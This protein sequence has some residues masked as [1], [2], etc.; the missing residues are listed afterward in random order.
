M[1]GKNYL[2]AFTEIPRGNRS[3]YCHSFQSFIWNQIASFRFRTYGLQLV[4]GDLVVKKK[5]SNE[6]KE[7]EK[8]EKDTKIE[9]VKLNYIRDF[10]NEDVILIDESNINDYAIFDVVL[11]LIGP[12]TQNPKN[13]VNDEIRRLLSELEIDHEKQLNTVGDIFY[14]TGKYRRFLAKPI[15][16][17]Y[18]LVNYDDNTIR[19]FSTDLD[20][21]N[22]VE[23][24]CANE[25]SKLG[26]KLDFFLPS[27]TYATILVRELS[28]QNV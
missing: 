22:K 12:Q 20:K 26:I 15:D 24:N 9:K 3:F 13:A 5:A 21:L 4:I 23:Y 18:E 11:P 28:R 1:Y 10:D 8:N 6:N 19:L 2:Q 27:S 14:I 25:G 16:L 17:K 7:E